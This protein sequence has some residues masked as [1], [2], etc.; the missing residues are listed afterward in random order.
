MNPKQ[1]PQIT[2]T[3]LIITEI[4]QSTNI[5]FSNLTLNIKKIEK[6][7]D[8]KVDE[9]HY[10]IVTNK[11]FNQKN[12]K[13]SITKT[14]NNL[15]SITKQIHKSGKMFSTIITTS[16][17][18]PFKKKINT[19]T[20]INITQRL[21]KIKINEILLTD[22]INYAV[23][24]QIQKQLTT[25]KTTINSSVTTNYHFHNTHNTNIT[26]AVTAIKSGI[27]ILNTSVNNINN[28]PFTPH[29]TNNISTKNLYYVLRN[30]NYTTN[31]DL[32]T[33]IDVTN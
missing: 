5:R 22:T 17:S 18:Y 3:K 14:L 21:D 16:F 15:K 29:T 28:Y 20:I 6:T 10:I 25:I 9:V 2:N 24:N 27:Q 19:N 7:L 30:I 33:L 32:T 31:I 4:D 23:P 11:T 26:N 8:T 1:I 13:T 12:Q